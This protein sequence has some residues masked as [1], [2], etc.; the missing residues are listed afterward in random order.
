MR[1]NNSKEKEE[2]Y[3]Y[4]GIDEMQYLLHSYFLSK[5]ANYEIEN[6]RSPL[7]LSPS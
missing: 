1:K 4:E 3:Y 6:D 7:I 2:L 5:A